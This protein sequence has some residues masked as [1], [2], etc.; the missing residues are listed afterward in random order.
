MSSYGPLARGGEA[1]Q[2]AHPAEPVAVHSPDPPAPPARFA[3]LPDGGVANSCSLRGLGRSMNPPTESAGAGSGAALERPLPEG[4]RQRSWRQAASPG[5]TA[6]TWPG[7]RREPATGGASQGNSRGREGGSRAGAKGRGNSGRFRLI[8]RTGHPGMMGEAVE[9]A[10][11]CVTTRSYSPWAVRPASPSRTVRGARRVGA[12]AGGTQTAS[13]SLGTDFR[14]AARLG[15]SA[16]RGSPPG[17][18]AEPARWMRV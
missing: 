17:E 18:P 8:D 9:P 11:S 6:G 14:S 2:P 7:R 16:V 12:I 13:V 10:P 5:V 4:G 15:R 3:E 1:G